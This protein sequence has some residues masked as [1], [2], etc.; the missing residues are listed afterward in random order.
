MTAATGQNIGQSLKDLAH[1]YG[2]PDHLTFDGAQAQVGR[3][4][5]FMQTIRKYD[6]KYHVSAPRRPN[7]NPAEGSIRQL[8]MRWYRVMVKKKV[9]KRLWDYGMIWVT[10][11]GNLTV[12][13]SRY[14]NGR[15]PL[16]CITGATPDISKYLDFGFYD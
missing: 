5:V 12:S 1:D 3:G 16:E 9:P 2:V 7:E 8:K 13:S 14:A 11:T 4:T 15:T 6:T 10:E